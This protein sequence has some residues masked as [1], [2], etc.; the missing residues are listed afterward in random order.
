MSRMY[1][2]KDCTCS[3]CR[4]LRG[5]KPKI[6]DKKN[7]Y[8]NQSNFILKRRLSEFDDLP[9]DYKQH[10]RMRKSQ[11][12]SEINFFKGD[13]S[14]NRKMRIFNPDKRLMKS[15]T[16]LLDG[17]SD[18]PKAQHKV[19]IYFGDS[20]SKNRIVNKEGSSRDIHHANLLL[21]ETAEMHENRN[22]NGSTNL[23]EQLK[24][25]I[26]NPELKPVR[27]APAPVLPKEN[28]KKVLS[29]EN[30]KVENSKK[31]SVDKVVNK[32][33]D[34]VVDKKVEKVLPNFIESVVNGVINIKIEEN[35][36]EAL[37]IVKEVADE[38]I[39]LPNFDDTFTGEA[40][41]WSFVQEWRSR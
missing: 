20:L 41:D 40:F 6:P 7:C 27:K 38:P 10:N 2:S 28:L 25:K 18:L 8:Q 16:N 32:V 31:K 34:K 24:K 9:L 29:K 21:E 3:L 1:C 14:E 19:V 15:T 12:H 26:E 13:F 4:E 30:L 17:N 37:R 23:M 11:S 5:F 33:V 36:E 35:F 39:E 22:K